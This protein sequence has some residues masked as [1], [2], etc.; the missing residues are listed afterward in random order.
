MTD[1]VKSGAQKPEMSREQLVRAHFEAHRDLMWAD[2]MEPRLKGYDLN[3]DAMKPYREAW[4]AFVEKRDWEWWRD[5]TRRSTND[6]LKAEIGD[7]LREL[8]SREMR[9]SVHGRADTGRQSFYEILNREESTEARRTEP[10]QTLSKEK[11]M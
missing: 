10:M 11:Q 8:K 9:Q 4:N 2:A 7:C 5:E 6:E 1:R 3:G